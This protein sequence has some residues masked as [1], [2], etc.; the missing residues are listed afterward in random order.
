[1]ADFFGSFFGDGVIV[2]KD[3]YA[4]NVGRKN[5]DTDLTVYINAGRMVIDGRVYINT[6]ILPVVI[7][8]VSGMPAYARIVIRSDTAQFKIYAD[9]ITGS[10]LP[11][12]TRNNQI[13]E[14]SLCNIY[15]PA[16]VTDI[17]DSGVAITDERNLAEVCGFFSFTASDAMR[18][19]S[20]TVFWFGGATAPAGWLECDG[21]LIDRAAYPDLFNVIGTVYN[22]VDDVDTT[23]FRIMDLRGEFIRGFDNGRG[24]DAEREYG[25][26]QNSTRL[27]VPNSVL[28]NP[29]T[30]EVPVKYESGAEDI[31]ASQKKETIFQTGSSV[32]M[33]PYYGF[34]VHPRNVALLPIIKI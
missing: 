19:P 8:A 27:K 17:N 23:K 21:A 14:M 30:T 2:T 31:I 4:L 25:S 11:A 32:T 3:P 18:V 1:M 20:G 13:Y 34:S 33:T 5:T 6:D 26:P 29:Y 16:N 12:I 15:I 28:M 9:V 24:V 22:T 7:P 10:S